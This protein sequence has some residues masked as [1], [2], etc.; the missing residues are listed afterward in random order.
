MPDESEA[1]NIPAET[2]EKG[3]L[4]FLEEA[5]EEGEAY[6]K[7]QVG[8][9][10]ISQSIDMI[11][12]KQRDL[13]PSML[14]TTSYPHG[15]KCAAD[16]AAMMTDTRPFWEY[17][18]SNPRYQQWQSN[19]GKLATHWWVYRHQDMRLSEVI[20]YALVGA[21]SYAHIDWNP[22][23][24]QGGDLE[25]IGEDPRD[26]IPIRPNGNESIQNAL[27]VMV[28]RGR[29]VNYLRQRYPS[30]AHL[31]IPD[32]DASAVTLSL[33][34]TRAGRILEALGGSPFM[35]RLWGRKPANETPRVP[36]ATVYTV[37]L[38][39]NSRNETK[40]TILMGNWDKDPITGRQI[41]L[42]NW[43]YEVKP[44]GLKYPR[45]RRITATRAAVLKDGPNPFWHGMFPLPKLTLDPWP[46]SWLGKAPL[47]DLLSLQRSLDRDMRIVDD[48]LEKFARPDIIADKNSVPKQALNKWDTRR[49]GG[50]YQHNPIAGKGMQI[51]Y[52]NPLDPSVQWH[53]DLIKNAMSDVSGVAALQSVM[54]L[55]QMPSADTVDKII[56]SMSPSVRARSRVLE[57][58]VSEVA[59]IMAFNF[60]QFYTL[61]MRL[62]VLGPNG[63][64]REDFDF[65]PGTIIPDFVHAQDMDYR[66]IPTSDAINRGPLPK[67]ERAQEFMRQF[68]FHTAPGS[69]LSASD[70]ED[71]LK[72][73]QLA[74]SGL[75]DHWTLLEKLNVPN[76]GMPADLPSDITGRLLYEQK[77]GLGMAISPTGRKASGD[78]P[79]RQVVKES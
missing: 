73:L 78:K 40:D 3:V 55:A 10:R 11:M 52:P 79:P 77:V 37:Y 69:M 19:L 41:A 61:P 18:V 13:K 7:A 66:G 20:K 42:D 34:S 71:Q 6:L 12:G 47:W 16:L 30:K 38:R 64:T 59:I 17:R 43:S 70:M 21:S 58:F 76:V 46:W 28:R 67:Y 25:M 60:A 72:Y 22:D 32:A 49:A 48:H 33:N 1:R 53:V 44:G 9:E 54:Q 29:T 35:D 14:S 50:K 45:G 8:Y 23:L 57:A 26:V 62:M 65:D 4:G 31:I 74:R 27:G 39:D 15:A 75:V 24:P 63:V 51:V 56:A 5:L 2:W 68:T 36:T